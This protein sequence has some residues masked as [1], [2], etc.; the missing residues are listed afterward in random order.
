MRGRAY[1]L[2]S[3]V[4]ARLQDMT[5]RGVRGSAYMALINSFPLYE[6]S[7]KGYLSRGPGNKLALSLCLNTLGAADIFSR[8][9]LN[10]GGNDEALRSLISKDVYAVR[11]LPEDDRI[12]Y[13]LSLV[14][15]YDTASNRDAVRQMVRSFVSVTKPRPAE[16]LEIVKKNSEKNPA[17]ELTPLQALIAGKRRASVHLAS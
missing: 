9:G 15:A 2:A 1:E 12:A 3:S 16:V 11:K 13:F 8:I 10:D 14:G 17:V 5:P 6:G 7:T 4:K